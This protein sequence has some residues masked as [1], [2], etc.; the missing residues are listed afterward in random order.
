[1]V[2][3]LNLRPDPRLEERARSPRLESRPRA[4]LDRHDLPVGRHVEEL[5]AVLSPPGLLSSALR[6]LAPLARAGEAAHADL[7]ATRFIRLVREPAAVRGETR[8]RLIERGLQHGTAG[9]GLHVA[10]PHVEV[11][12]LDVESL[13]EQ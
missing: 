13:V 10:H 2:A 12:S 8:P 7:G 11:V 4:D 1:M 3:H 6:D 5:L 9:S